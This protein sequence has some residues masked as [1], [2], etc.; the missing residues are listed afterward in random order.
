VSFLDFLSEANR[1]FFG[2]WIEWKRCLILWDSVCVLKVLLGFCLLAGFVDIAKFCLLSCYF[3]FPP[4]Y[5]PWM[6]L[7]M[8]RFYD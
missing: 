6:V 1:A 2:D 7:C 5:L 3:S 4:L 8:R